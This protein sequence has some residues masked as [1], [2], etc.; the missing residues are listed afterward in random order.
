ME[1]VKPTYK[2]GGRLN[3]LMRG[4]KPPFFLFI[5]Y[6]HGIVVVVMFVIGYDNK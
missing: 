4:R 1:R 3:T 2:L 5:F 6:L